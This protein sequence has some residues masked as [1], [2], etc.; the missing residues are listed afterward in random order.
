MREE[1]WATIFKP[2]DREGMPISSEAL[3]LVQT[4]A[5]R[6]PAHGSF[7]ID[8]INGERFRI[9]VTS[10]PIQGRPDRYLGA[11]AMFWKSES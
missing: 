7:Y 10:F 8:N 4:L 1:E 2:S 3:P 11:I 9:T 6:K 5:T